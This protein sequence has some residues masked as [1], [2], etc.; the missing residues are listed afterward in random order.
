MTETTNRRKIEAFVLGVA[1][2]VNVTLFGFNAASSGL[3]NAASVLVMSIVA[4]LATAAFAGFCL[5]FLAAG[6]F[7]FFEVV[8]LLTE[9]NGGADL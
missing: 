9:K 5:A 8:E 1:L 2:G 6:T 4:T 3:E 7:V